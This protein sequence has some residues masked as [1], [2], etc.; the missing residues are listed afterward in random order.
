MVKKKVT[1]KKASKK[2]A[3]GAINK[4]ALQ[5]KTKKQLKDAQKRLD[6]AEKAFNSGDNH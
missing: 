4:R 2:K 6:A 5:A 1:K 3:T